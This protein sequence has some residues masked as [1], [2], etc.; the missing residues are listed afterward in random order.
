M[1]KG[2]KGDGN[3]LYLDLNGSNMGADICQNPL[4][5]CLK[6]VNFIVYKQYL[7]RLLSAQ[8]KALALSI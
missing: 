5:E 3:S 2:S 6:R 8:F 4:N 7:T 1:A